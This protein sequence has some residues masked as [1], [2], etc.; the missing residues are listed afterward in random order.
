MR[1]SPLYECNLLTLA[2]LQFCGRRRLA[3]D[4]WP[5][6]ALYRV[7]SALI[8]RPSDAKISLPA[9][10]KKKKASRRR[11]IFSPPVARARLFSPRLTIKV[12]ARVHKRQ[13]M[14]A[15]FLPRASGSSNHNT[16]SFG[17]S[18]QQFPELDVVKLAV[19]QIEFIK[20][21]SFMILRHLVQLEKYA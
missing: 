10:L 4:L 3:R 5:L 12:H 14:C 15:L 6:I 17:D 20:Q 11:F 8:V 7:L 19:T 9:Q 2:Q 16:H 1:N 21:K 18:A 13:G